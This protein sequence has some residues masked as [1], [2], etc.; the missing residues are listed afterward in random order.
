MKTFSVYTLITQCNLAL[1]H[2]TWHS[3]AAANAKA[4]TP[5]VAGP[6]ARR[7]KSFHYFQVSKNTVGSLTGQNKI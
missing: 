3:R 4:C 6:L 2:S 1:L 5:S 7:R